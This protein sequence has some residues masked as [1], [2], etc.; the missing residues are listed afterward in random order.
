MQQIEMC[1]E[2]D[3]RR[4]FFRKNEF[5]RDETAS[6]RTQTI[7]VYVSL[8]ILYGNNL[9]EGN[10]YCDYGY[11]D[12]VK[13]TQGCY[14]FNTTNRHVCG[15]NYIMRELSEDHNMARIETLSFHHR[16]N[17]HNEANS[18]LQHKNH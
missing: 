12:T 13:N 9:E 14:G 4:V 5:P 6:P 10:V 2:H 17:G 7:S 16:A 3:H 15:Y 11:D 8:S 18:S 1:L